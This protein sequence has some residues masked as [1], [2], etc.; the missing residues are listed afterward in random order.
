MEFGL[1]LPQRENTDLSRD[2]T[3]VAREAEA[4]GYASLWAYERVLFPL[5]PSDGMYQVPGLPWLDAYRYTAEALTVLTVAGAV[6]ERVRLGTCVLIAGLHPTLHLARTLATLDQITG[7]GRVVAGFGSGWSSDEYRA[8]GADIRH[9]G[10]SLDETVDGLRAL[11]GPNPVTYRDSRMVVE[12]ALVT[13]KPAAP[14]PLYLAGGGSQ[15]TLERIARKADGWIPT[16]MPIAA[17]RDTYRQIQD[18]VVAAGRDAD[19]VPMTPLLHLLVTDEPGGSDRQE[20]Q[21]SVEQVVEDMAG[22]VAAGVR[23]AILSFSDDVVGKEFSDRAMHFLDALR[24][25][26]LTG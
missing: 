19:A 1:V 16:G 25:A 2:V 21:G 10:R 15:A 11:W 23:E 5:E 9:R 20:L 17:M 22:L 12:N 7:G 24:T 3:A 6:T 18:L 8:Y 4:A 13:P 26:G 14:I